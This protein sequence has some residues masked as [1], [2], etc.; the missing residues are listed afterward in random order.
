MAKRPTLTR[1]NIHE[2]G[3]S[4][5]AVTSRVS[6]NK[7]NA[8]KLKCYVDFSIGRIFFMCFVLAI[9]LH[10]FTKDSDELIIVPIEGMIQKVKDMANNPTVMES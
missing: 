10:F 3:S 5:S 7:N 4:L 9:L 1:G 8:C 6:M 2:G